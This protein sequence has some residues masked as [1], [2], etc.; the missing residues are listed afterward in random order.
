MHIF[1]P[2]ADTSEDFQIFSEL[3]SGPSCLRDV[4]HVLVKPLDVSQELTETNTGKRVAQI[5]AM[6]QPHLSGGINRSQHIFCSLR[7]AQTLSDSYASPSVIAPEHDLYLFD[8]N[9][10]KVKI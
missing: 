7:V 4:A 3:L 1:I 8:P 10:D 6:Y 2:I 5:K 9:G